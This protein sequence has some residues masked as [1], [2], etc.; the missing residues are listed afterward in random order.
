VCAGVFAALTFGHRFQTRLHPQSLS[1]SRK[2]GKPNVWP[3]TPAFRARILK[4]K[5]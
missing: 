2:P 1:L 3:G 5:G 4:D